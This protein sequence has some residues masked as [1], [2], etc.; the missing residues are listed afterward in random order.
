MELSLD[1][2]ADG[3][4]RVE[5]AYRN[6]YLV[7]GGAQLTVVDAGVPTSWVS[8]ETALSRI[9]RKLDDIAAVVLTARAFRPLGLRRACALAAR[10][11]GLGARG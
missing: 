9:G 1:Q 3:V 2:P 4:H 8:L 6:W 10:R 11:P 7:E 5:D